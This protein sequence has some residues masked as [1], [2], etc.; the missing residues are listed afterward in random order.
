MNKILL[1]ILFSSINLKLRIY[2]FEVVLS[3]L[4]KDNSWG[5]SNKAA[6]NCVI[7]KYTSKYSPQ[8]NW[9]KSEQDRSKG[10][11]GKPQINRGSI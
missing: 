5:Y 3:H 8:E 1:Y 11:I 6:K 9:T 4:N 2:K 10:A 7:W